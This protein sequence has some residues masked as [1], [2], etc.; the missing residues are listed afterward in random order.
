M[1]LTLEN[2]EILTPL[3]RPPHGRGDPSPDGCP[4]LRP[5]PHPRKSVLMG[6]VGEWGSVFGFRVEDSGLRAS[7]AR[8]WGFEA[9][10]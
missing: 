8:A 7:D 4:V 9:G 6:G 5:S 10:G 1:G 3:P 2:L